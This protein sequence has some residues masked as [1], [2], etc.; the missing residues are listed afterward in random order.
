MTL[1]LKMYV[2][3]RVA[4]IRRNMLG[5]KFRDLSE[6]TPLHHINGILNPADLLTKQS[7]VS[8]E[9][10]TPDHRWFKGEQWM[11]VP[12]A[13]LPG[14]SFADLVLSSTQRAELSQ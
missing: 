3:S 2:R 13:E 14:T 4:E 5:A 11:R 1:K 6:E 7:Q 12:S 10:L 8:P 9:R